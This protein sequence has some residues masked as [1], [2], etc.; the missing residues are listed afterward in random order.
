MEVAIDLLA[1]RVGFDWTTDVAEHAEQAR[2]PFD[3][4]RR[5][6]SVIV[7]GEVLVKG[8]PDSVLPRCRPVDGARK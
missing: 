2:F 4:R 3:A 7:E 6:M 8:A 1:R 5:R